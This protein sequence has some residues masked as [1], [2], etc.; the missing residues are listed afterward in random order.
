M[1]SSN[2]FAGIAARKTAFRLSAA[3]PTVSEARYGIGESFSSP[4]EGLAFSRLGLRGSDPTQK[5]TTPREE[6][7]FC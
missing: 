5:T 6:R 4:R 2:M 7:E 3:K 1:A